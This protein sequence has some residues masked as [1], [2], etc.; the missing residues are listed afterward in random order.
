MDAIGYVDVPKYVP[1]VLLADGD[2]L[3]LDGVG[4][5]SYAYD[6]MEIDLPPLR[7]YMVISYRVGRTPVHRRAGSAWRD[8]T[9][10][11]RDLTLLT[12]SC[13]SEWSWSSAIEVSHVYLSQSF[14]ESV[15]NEV[16]E[17]NV[18]DIRLGDILRTKD[19]GISRCVARIGAEVGN[20][21]LGERLIV[22]AM[23]RELA[24]RLLRRH[25]RDYLIDDARQGHLSREQQAR[26][27]AFVLDSL[28]RDVSYRDA[29]REVGLGPWNFSRRFKASFGCTFHQYVVEARVSA[30]AMEITRS[31][32]PLKAVAVDCGFSDQSHMTRAFGKILGY[33]P[34][35]LR[36]SS[37]IVERP[38]PTIPSSLRAARTFVSSSL[39]GPVYKD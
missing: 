5:R 4:Y 39:P 32:K 1:G 23:S 15:A 37:Q 34:G 38:R 28:G 18:R 29:A 11:V 26:V 6:G 3:G 36:R 27:R 9:C 14:V 20:G 12:R 17:R 31:R 35:Y 25:T 16:F 21:G 24:V 19:E 13:R 7:D 22:D 2:R 8:E 30:A 10:G 33:T